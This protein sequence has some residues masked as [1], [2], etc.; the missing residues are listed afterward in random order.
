MDQPTWHPGS[1]LGLSGSYWQTFALHT[2]VKLDIFTIIGD[3]SITSQQISKR[4]GGDEDGTERLLN[5]LVAM[6]LLKK[7]KD[8]FLN[9][10]ASSQFL[11]KDSKAYIGHMIMHH[12]HLVRSWSKMDE[13]ILSGQPV[14]SRTSFSDENVRKAF[15]MGMFNT[16]MQS[17]PSIVKTLDLSRYTK[18]LDLGGGPGTYA[19]HFCLQNPRL[20]AV[21]YDLPTTRPFAQNTISQFEL[22]ERITFEEG[23]YVSEA[24][25][26]HYDV[27]WMSH[28]LHGEGPEDCQRMIDKAVAVLEPGGMLVIHDFFLE[29]DKAGPL[30]PALFSINMYLGTPEGRSYSQGEIS[31]MLKQAGLSDIQRSEYQGPTQSGILMSKKRS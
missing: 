24:I 22:S 1:L 16:A 20:K 4:I 28:I 5:A 2:A 19:I 17:A 11:S 8:T 7:E 14:R 27:V 3:G 25:Q 18:L 23:N 12:H 21:V 10:Q 29:E 13:A 9:T 31:D 15:L 30:F 26:G 6:V